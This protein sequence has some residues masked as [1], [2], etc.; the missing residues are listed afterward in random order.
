MAK[1][2][3]AILGVL[4]TATPEE[5]RSAYRSR[6]KQYH[7]DRFGK[8]ST[9]FLRIQEAYDVLSDPENRRLYDQTLR[10]QRAE[11]M[12]VERPEPLTHP[13][14]RRAAETLRRAPGETDLGT[15]FPMESFRTFR[16]SFDEI[17]DTLW[18]VFDP[19]PQNKAERFRTL[20]ME[21]P[22]TRDQARWGGRLQVYVPVERLC[23]EC[24]G[25]G[26][27]SYFRCRLCGGT[28][29]VREEMPLEV[30]FP[31]GIQDRFE[32]AIP[33]D[34]YGIRDVRPVLLFRVGSIAGF[35]GF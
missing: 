33:L 4:P 24:G 21:I 34:R 12:Q 31:P 14:R 18:N 27:L 29:A 22:L 16:P 5:I 32:I 19:R 8:D 20:T 11:S 17:F 1:D 2:Y 3:Y 9:P 23:P 15:I 6:V 13:S 30:E 28:G 26:R 10:R 25:A 7:P 35:E